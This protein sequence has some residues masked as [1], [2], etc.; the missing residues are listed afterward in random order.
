MATIPITSTL[1]I[2]AVINGSK[3]TC[4]WLMYRVITTAIGCINPPSKYVCTLKAI[5]NLQV[6]GPKDVKLIH[7]I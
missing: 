5:E 7:L 1:S 4:G 6:L 3:S 2:F